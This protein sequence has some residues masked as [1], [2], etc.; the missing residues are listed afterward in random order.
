MRTQRSMATIQLFAK[1]GK[2]LIVCRRPEL[3][4][5]ELARSSKRSA[6]SLM[7]GFQNRCAI[8]AAMPAQ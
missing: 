4:T 6:T 8:V 1:S 7:I 5:R 3:P 2:G